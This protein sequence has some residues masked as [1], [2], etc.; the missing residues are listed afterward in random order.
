VLIG[1]LPKARDLWPYADNFP[2]EIPEQLRLLGVALALP[3]W[4]GQPLI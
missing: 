2:V 4:R 1:A 3:P